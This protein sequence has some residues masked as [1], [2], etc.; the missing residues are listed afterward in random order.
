MKATVGSSLVGSALGAATGAA[1]SGAHDRS[2]REPG[3]RADGDLDVFVSNDTVQNFVFRNEGDG[4][5]SELGAESGHVAR[6]PQHLVGVLEDAGTGDHQQGLAATDA[7]VADREAAG[8]AHAQ[9]SS[10]SARAAR[11]SSAYCLAYFFR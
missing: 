11:A 4:T 7:C 9:A 1:A 10:A 3:V 6:D 5:F 8:L 2:G